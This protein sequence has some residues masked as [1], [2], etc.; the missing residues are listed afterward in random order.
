MSGG[1][2]YCWGFNG[3]GQLGDGTNRLVPVAVSGGRTYTALVAGGQHTCGL[4]SGGT[5]YCWGENYY[6]QLGDGTSGTNRTAPVAVIRR[7]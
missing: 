3:Q 1:T 4:V 7:A 5:A 2:A 6:G